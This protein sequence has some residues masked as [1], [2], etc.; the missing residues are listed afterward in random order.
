MMPE[1]G[2][3]EKRLALTDSIPVG[4]QPQPLSPLPTER[5]C[6]RLPV[7][8]LSWCITLKL[9]HGAPSRTTDCLCK[10][11]IDPTSKNA[12]SS[13]S[14]SWYR[15]SPQSRISNWHFWNFRLPRESPRAPIRLTCSAP[16]QTA[17]LDGPATGMLAPAGST[18]FTVIRR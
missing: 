7:A 9:S 8:L 1:S 14:A 2:I 3:Q 18:R 11:T 17:T 16:M 5:A 15:G 4:R 6:E 12:V 13:E 10:K